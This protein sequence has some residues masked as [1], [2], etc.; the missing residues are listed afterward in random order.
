MSSVQW[1][2]KKSCAFDDYISESWESDGIMAILMFLFGKPLIEHKLYIFIYSFLLLAYIFIG[3]VFMIVGWPWHFLVIW[4]ISFPI[5]VRV[6]HALFKTIFNGLVHAPKSRFNRKSVGG[7]IGMVLFNIIFA[8]A[9][10]LYAV[11]N[12]SN[13]YLVLNLNQSQINN[14]AYELSAGTLRGELDSDFYIGIPSSEPDLLVQV[15]YEAFVG[16]GSFTIELFNKESDDVIWSNEVDDRVR[17]AI[18]IPAVE[19]KYWF[20]LIAD[21]TVKDITF[22]FS[23]E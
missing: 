3:T 16:E 4:G 6:N 19:G 8:I 11:Y 13:G 9:F 18:Q 5:T 14:N 1:Y 20:R 2:E 7:F 22:R 12:G 17:G 10:I 21:E 23:V 15:Q